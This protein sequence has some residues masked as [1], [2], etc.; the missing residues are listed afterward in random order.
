[1]APSP[2]M[3]AAY[4]LEL[5]RAPSL[6][7]AYSRIMMSRKPPL[8]PEGATV[9]RI[10]ARLAHAAVEPRRLARYAALC[11]TGTQTDAAAAGALPIAYPHVL[12]ASVHLAMLGGNAFPVRLLGLVHVRNR[13]VLR[14]PLSVDT[15]AEIRC[16]IEGHRDTERGQEFDLQTEYRVAGETLWDETCTF[17]ARSRGSAREPRA[18]PAREEDER[19]APSLLG[20]RTFDAPSGLGR[21]YAAVSGD[22]NPIHLWDLTARMFGFRRAIAHGMWMLAR[23]AAELGA[24]RFACPCELDVSFRRP[25]ALPSRVTLERWPI[26]RGI[27]FAL[28]DADGDKPHLIGALATPA[29]AVS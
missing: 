20:T 3:Q 21:R 5:A 13:I 29:A 24:E 4:S 25:V 9:P 26:D 8:V 15:P 7:S 1:M 10:E 11:G 18:S 6:W 17:L 27:G 28:R 23:T 12:A 2:A 16:S 19:A 22:F 14:R